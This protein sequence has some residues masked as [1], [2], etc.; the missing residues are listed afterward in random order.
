MLL[1]FRDRPSDCSFIERVWSCRSCA[2]GRF[3]SVASSHWEIV[4]TRLRA[5]TTSVTLRGPET[6]V[7]DLACPADA[8]WL[9]I[10][11]KIG[12]FMPSWPVNRLI[13]GQDVTIV[14]GD[15]RMF[16]LD[17]EALEI[18]T[19]DNAE[20]FV[21]RLVRAGLVVREAA[22]PAILDGE[23]TGFSQ[24]TGQRRFLSATGITLSM[25]RQIQRA[26]LATTFL[27]QG[28][29]IA[30]AAHAAGFFDQ[31]HLTRALRGFI[32]QT[33]GQVASGTQQLSFLYNTAVR[34]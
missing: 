4:V 23:L 20:T 24:R 34:L 30:E 17:A 25:F 6:K 3:L 19:F 26:R 2:D 7:R 27:R 11:F 10:R 13:D 16:W 15:N 22:V 18:P 28:L 21:S 32:G 5:G 33:P 29:P 14:S 8:E 31:A 9:G 1:Q 12:T